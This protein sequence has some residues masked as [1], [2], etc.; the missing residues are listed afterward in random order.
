MGLTMRERQAVTRELTARF[1]KAT[2]KERGRMLDEFVQLT[3]Y[4]RVYAAYVL[5]SCGRPEVRLVHGRRIVFVPGHGRAPGAARKTRR[6]PREGYQS[7]AF[8]LVL[9]RLWA[10]SDGLC[11]KRLVAFLRELVPELQA[12]GLL[13]LK[14]PHLG[15]LLVSASAATLDRLLSPVKRQ[16]LLEN[17]GRSHTRPGTLLKHHVP[18]RTFADWSDVR[19]GFCEVDLVAHDGGSAFGEYAFTLTLTDVATGWTELAV[20]PNK[21]QA[22]VFAALQEIRR[23]LPFPLLGLDC[24]NGSEFINFQLI[25]YCEREAITFTRSRPYKKND[26]CFVEQKNYSIV[27]RT[28]GYSRYDRPR[29]RALLAELYAQMGP[30]GNFFQP[31]MKLKEKIRVGSHLT[32]RYDTAQTPYRRLLGHAQISHEAKNALEARYSQLNILDLK[33]ELHRLQ[34][35]LF[36]AARKAGP[37]PEPRRFPYVPD[38][39]HPWRGHFVTAREPEDYASPSLE[40]GTSV[41]TKAL[42]SKKKITTL[43][44]ATATPG[45]HKN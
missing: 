16:M 12:R 40:H 7:P 29:Q 11:G 8:L 45:E 41:L 38:E 32:R 36:A 18:I 3:G 6:S 30:F 17:K 33:R 39:A 5:R 9:K 31:V 21:A 35:E 43:P 25:R 1:R 14:D 19:P 20:V 42:T 34:S 28:V 2:K 4:N 44:A 10:L 22:H 24:D 26:N 13:K 27:R 15:T 37:P 23:R